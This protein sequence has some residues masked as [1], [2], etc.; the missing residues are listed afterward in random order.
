M[1]LAWCIAATVCAASMAAILLTPSVRR[2]SGKLPATKLW[3]LTLLVVPGQALPP[4]LLW[5]AWKRTYYI[6]PFLGPPIRVG[7]PAVGWAVCALFF[8]YLPVTIYALR[9]RWH[10]FWLLVHPIATFRMLWR[11]WSTGREIK[12]QKNVD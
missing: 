12:L 9:G 2:S 7:M 5:L 8:S 4:I 11:Q 1:I 10:W 3:L 6:I